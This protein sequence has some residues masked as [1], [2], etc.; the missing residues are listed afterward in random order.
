MQNAVDATSSVTAQRLGK[1]RT[2]LFIKGYQ[3]AQVVFVMQCALCTPPPKINRM[4]D[5]QWDCSKKTFFF[6]I[7]AFL[8][9]EGC[10]ATLIYILA[11]FD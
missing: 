4:M 5:F 1:T 11:C 10:D 2:A 6:F 7:C 9:T 3:I 8:A